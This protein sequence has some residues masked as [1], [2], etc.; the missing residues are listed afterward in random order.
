MLA[1]FQRTVIDEL[2]RRA[3]LGASEIGARSVIISG[4]VASNQSLRAAAAKADLEAPVHFPTRALSTDNAVM[5]AAAAFAKA[6][7][8]EYADLTIAPY[9]TLANAPANTERLQRNDV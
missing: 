9:S 3:A 2:L 7:R 4:G 5:I 6:K 8:G 1:S